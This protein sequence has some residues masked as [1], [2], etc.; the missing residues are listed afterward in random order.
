ML[1]LSGSHDSHQPRPPVIE[2]VMVL[3][4]SHITPMDYNLLVSCGNDLML[5]WLEKITGPHTVF[6]TINYGLF[7]YVEDHEEEDLVAR[8]Q[9]HKAILR[10]LSFA[11]FRGCRF[12]R[13]TVDEDPIPELEEFIW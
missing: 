8:L 13:L 10:V 12:L 9:G 3:S 2:N 11:R 4:M 7:I 5:V 6:P 1:S